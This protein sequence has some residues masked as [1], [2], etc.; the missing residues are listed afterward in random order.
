MLRL[1]NDIYVFDLNKMQ[2]SN[3]M[4]L[5]VNNENA[6]LWHRRLCHFNMDAINEVS[7]KELVRGLPNLKF[8]KDRVCDTCQ[9]G[10]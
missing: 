2:N 5:N 9:Y 3:V 1:S 10:K 4:C 6:W 8:V 7:K